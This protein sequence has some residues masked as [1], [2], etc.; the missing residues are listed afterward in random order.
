MIT[1]LLKKIFGSRN[2]RLLRQYMH[3]VRAVNAL[4]PEVARLSDDALKAKT[5]EFKQRHANGETLDQLLPEAFAVV[6][7][8]GKR[9]LQ[10]RHFDVQIIGGIALHQGKIAEMRSG[11]GK[12]L[13]AKLHAYIHSLSGKGGHMATAKD[14]LHKRNASGS[15]W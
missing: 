1:G 12:T 13:V 11:E 15:A 9:V 14:Y 8:A 5:A 10:M 2:E 4:E 6:R 7:E 3:S